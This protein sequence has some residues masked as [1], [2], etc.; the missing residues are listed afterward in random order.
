MVEFNWVT[1][2]LGGV[3]IGIS[4]TLLLAFNG[5]IAGIS[6]MVNGAITFKPQETWRWVFRH[7]AGGWSVR[8]RPGSPTHA[9]F[10]FCAWG[11][12]PRGIAGGYRDAHWHR[13]HQW[14]RG[15]WVGAIVAAIADGGNHVF[16][17]GHGDGIC[18]SPCRGNMSRCLYTEGSAM[19][20]PK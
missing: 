3:L 8:I 6:G 2:L 16:K 11:D 20:E 18:N 15:M 13:L 4:A 19:V 12:D 10:Q 5:R 14:A 1:A 7:G 9:P 17:H